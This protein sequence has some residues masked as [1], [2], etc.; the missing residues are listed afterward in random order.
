MRGLFVFDFVRMLFF[1]SLDCEA[2]RYANGVSV[3]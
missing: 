3:L 1:F 2:R